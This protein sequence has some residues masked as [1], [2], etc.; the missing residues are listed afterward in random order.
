MFE[1]ESKKAVLKYMLQRKQILLYFTLTKEK[2]S[3]GWQDVHKFALS[4]GYHKK[5]WYIR[6]AFW[7]NIRQTTMVSVIFPQV[8]SSYI[9]L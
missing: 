1:K 9:C 4:L 7:P 3:A 6:D 5:E 8:C 2:K